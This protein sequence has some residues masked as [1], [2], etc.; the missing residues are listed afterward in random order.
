MMSATRK[1]FC[2]VRSSLRRASRLRALYLLIPAASSKR[3][4]DHAVGVGAQAGV[5]EQFADV[6]QAGGRLVQQ[7]LALAGAVQPA[8]DGD[9]VTVQ[10]Q[11]PVGV[12]EEQV[13]RGQA[14]A[15]ARGAAVEDHVQHL[16]AAQRLG[17]L[18]AEHPFEA[19]DHVALAAA[20]GPDDAGDARTEVEVHLVGEALETGQ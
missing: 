3:V 16:V 5:H 11:G 9:L 19:I 10:R 7:V 14:A 17:R 4:L 13:H 18:L 2:S 6:P 1:R 20:V 12:V 8:R 15:L